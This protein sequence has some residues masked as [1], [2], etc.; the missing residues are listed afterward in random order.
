MKLN[1]LT[2]S[3]DKSALQAKYKN[4]LFDVDVIE[5]VIGKAMTNEQAMLFDAEEF[6]FRYGRIPLNGEIGCV[7]S[8]FKIF[9]K[10]ASEQ[11]LFQVVCE[12]DALISQDFWSFVGTDEFKKLMLTDGE[13]VSFYT[14][15]SIVDLKSE[16]KIGTGLVYRVKNRSHCT[17]CYVISKSAAERVVSDIRRLSRVADWFFD[18]DKVKFLVV[19]N[20]FVQHDDGQS[21]IKDER[22]GN[23]TDAVLKNYVKAGVS[24][25]G[26]LNLYGVLRLMVGFYGEI[27]IPFTLS[28]F[29]RYGIIRHK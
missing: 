9:E 23:Y 15:G 16:K 26:K 7:L 29:G 20:H 19:V 10:I 14:E 28:R 22:A 17:V 18:L 6:F 5:G 2:I 12:D 1:V 24:C 4:N 25:L 8:H 21:R 11:Y 13:I 3:N 27:L